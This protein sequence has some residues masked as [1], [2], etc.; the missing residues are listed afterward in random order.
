MDMS[1]DRSGTVKAASTITLLAAVWLFVSP[2]IYAVYRLPNAWNSWIVGF[3]IAVLA[4]IR[5]GFPLEMPSLSWLNC[6]LGA[7]TLASPWIFKYN[8]DTGRQVNSLCVGVVVFFMALRSAS[9]TPRTGPS[10]PTGA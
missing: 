3:L 8:G 1:K 4:A 6:L 5:I 9:A 7:W 10:L 2:W